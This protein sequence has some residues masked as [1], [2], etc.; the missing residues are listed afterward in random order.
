MSNVISTAYQGKFKATTEAPLNDNPITV[1]A[2][3]FSPVDLLIS[4]YGSCLLGTID[5]VAQT[6]LF[7]V[8][9][10][11]SEITYEMSTTGSGVGK[12]NIKLFFK[13]DYSAEQREVIENA[14]K[15]QC[16]VGNTIDARIEK[17][18]QFIYSHS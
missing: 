14:A 11:K 10:S 3:Q 8:N 18:F 13:D 2:V 7:E 6:K 12:I 4:A 15:K 16:H 9:N 1:N 5:Y 17:E